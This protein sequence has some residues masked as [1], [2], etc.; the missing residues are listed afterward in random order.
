M[1]RALNSQAR[2]RIRL[3]ALI[4]TAKKGKLQ[5]FTKIKGGGYLGTIGGK[6]E[7]AWVGT[8]WLHQGGVGWPSK[9]IET[10]DLRI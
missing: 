7:V 5:S 2:G 6:S 10:C 8:L 4:H 9:R 1:V 3:K